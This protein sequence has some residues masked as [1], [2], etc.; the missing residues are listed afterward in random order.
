MND[1]KK[2]YQIVNAV[3]ETFDNGASFTLAASDVTWTSSA[4]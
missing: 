1:S 3:T 2:P 4:P